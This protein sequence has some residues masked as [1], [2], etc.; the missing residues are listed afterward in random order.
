MTRA[1]VRYLLGTPMVPGGFDNDRWDYD[2]YLK[3]AAAQDSAPRPRRRLLPQR[4]RRPRRQRRHAGIQ[5]GGRRLQRA[6][7]STRHRRAE[8]IRALPE[9]RDAAPDPVRHAPTDPPAAFLLSPRAART[10]WRRRW[11]GSTLS[12]RYS[13]M[14][15]PSRG[16]AL[17][18]QRTPQMP[19]AAPS[20]SMPA[21]IPVCRSWSRACSSAAAT[22]A[23]TGKLS[24]QSIGPCGSI[25]GQQTALAR[26]LRQG[27]AAP[28]S[29]RPAPSRSPRPRS[30]DRA[31][32][33]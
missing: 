7:R 13:S 10:R 5:R 11:R 29:R 12:A 31:A 18:P 23:S 19:L 25:E 26:L 28:G 22:V 21:S 1:Q 14:R 33:P 27:F 17:R 32:P 20:Q 16:T 24:A 4:S 30:A 9:P 3:I 6:R 15:S 2:Y 8:A